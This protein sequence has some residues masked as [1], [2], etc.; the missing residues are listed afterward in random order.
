LEKE[1]VMAQELLEVQGTVQTDG[2]LVL[3]EKLHLPAG[4]V[5]VTVQSIPET[6]KPDPSRLLALMEHIWADQ[7]ERG[8][9]PRSKQEI[10]A[11]IDELR[12]EADEEM[13]AA[14]RLDEECQ[15]GRQQAG[16]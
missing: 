16:E 8:H 3:D 12:N 10:D 9:V 7:R 5:R 4:R 13:Q 15:R 11:A 14:E 2:S 1:M 6:N